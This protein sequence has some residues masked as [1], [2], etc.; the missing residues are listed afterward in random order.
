M[1]PTPRV[2]KGA[3]RSRPRQTRHRGALAPERFRALTEEVVKAA[4]AGQ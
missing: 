2:G 1:E 3:G 4:V